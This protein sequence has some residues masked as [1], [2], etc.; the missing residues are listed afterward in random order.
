M[1]EIE[2]R[3]HVSSVDGLQGDQWVRPASAALFAATAAVAT[4]ALTRALRNALERQRAVSTRTT[5]GQVGGGCVNQP[6]T[7]S[8]SSVPLA[9]RPATFAGR[10]TAL[11]ARPAILVAR[12]TEIEATQVPALMNAAQ[13]PTLMDG[14][15][16]LAIRSLPLQRAKVAAL[17]GLAAA[18]LSVANAEA[19]QA[20]VKVLT[21]AG[22]VN[23]VARQ[24][25]VCEQVLRQ[26]NQALLQDACATLY[27]RSMS[28][29]GF[30][31]LTRMAGGPGIIRMIGTDLRGRSLVTELTMLHGE[32]KTET[33]LVGSNDSTCSAVIDALDT[34]LA[35]NGLHT[36]NPSRKP[37]GGICQSA[38]AK[39]LVKGGATRK[40]RRAVTANAQAEVRS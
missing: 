22:T 24:A 12:Q 29:I 36:S 21:Q 37:T 34:T 18:H 20:S 30:T 39:E 25:V 13:V 10:T 23:E 9:V 26:Q 19:L 32:L 40:A 7:L 14:A 2:T 38:A 8:A 31:Q 17:A 35:R 16:Q 3:S 6:T 33:E 27:E 15:R 11:A 28:E 4:A 5:A 1:S